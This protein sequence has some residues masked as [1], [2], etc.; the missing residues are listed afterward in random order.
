MREITIRTPENIELTYSLAGAG[1]RFLAILLDTLFKSGALMIIWGTLNIIGISLD[2]NIFTEK[3]ACVKSSLT[4]T[5]LLLGA[6]GGFIIIGYY[7]FFETLWNGQ[8]PGKRIAGLK[9]MKDN[10]TAISIIDATVRNFLRIIDFVPSFY[11]LGAISILHS[12]RNQRIGDMAAGTIVVKIPMEEI[13]VVMPEIEVESPLHPPDIGVLEEKEYSL[14]RNFIIRRNELSSAVR[15]KLA[16]L[17]G[18]L[19]LKKCCLQEN[20]F[21]TAEELLEWIVVNYRK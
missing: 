5:I 13:P 7:I 16:T 1:S 11:L 12:K 18:D 3:L 15:K 4:L 19:M 6:L 2:L 14:A 20:P 17:L 10:G 9:V 21:S 8:T